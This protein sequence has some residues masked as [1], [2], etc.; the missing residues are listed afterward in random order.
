MKVYVL[1]GLDYGGESPVA[2][3]K[4]KSTAE[5][6]E[7]LYENKAIVNQ[8]NHECYTIDEMDLID[9]E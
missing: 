6:Y 4:F 9:D 2:V 1:L 3:F 7:K 8:P 5:K